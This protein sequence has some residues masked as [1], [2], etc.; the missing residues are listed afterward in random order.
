MKIFLNTLY[1]TIHSNIWNNPRPGHSPRFEPRKFR[2]SEKLNW[3]NVVFLISTLS[4]N[5]KLKNDSDEFILTLAPSITIGVVSV[6]GRGQS[7]AII[8][9]NKPSVREDT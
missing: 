3:S 7:E 6:Q 9:V 5:A 1:T 2:D 8:P 4:E